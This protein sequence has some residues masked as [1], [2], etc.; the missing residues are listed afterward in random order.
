[1]LLFWAS[2]WLGWRFPAPRQAHIR[3]TGMAMVMVMVT[4]RG[5]MVILTVKLAWLFCRPRFTTPPAAGV[6]RPAAGLLRAPAGLLRARALSALW[7]LWAAWRVAQFQVLKR[8]LRAAAA[9]R[10][11][12][13]H[14]H[15]DFT[16]SAGS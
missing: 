5:R 3:N 4:T 13:P 12:A 7:T 8:A 1:M 15:I 10:N 16:Q 9:P 11:F 6:L 2:V 14:V